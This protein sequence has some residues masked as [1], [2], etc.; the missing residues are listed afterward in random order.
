MSARILLR[1]ST[2]MCWI[3]CT[4]T[5]YYYT[6]SYVIELKQCNIQK[7][8]CFETFF[9][10]WCVFCNYRRGHKTVTESSHLSGFLLTDCSMKLSTQNCDND[11]C[12]WN[13][14]KA[15]VGSMGHLTTACYSGSH[16]YRQI[17][18]ITDKGEK[19][20]EKHFWMKTVT[21]KVRDKRLKRIDVYWTDN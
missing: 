11:W 13:N 5:K 18:K 21:K 12:H 6:D 20:T 17:Y 2:V 14:G 8:H 9:P 16:K 10:E 1:Q 15:L 7:C 4:A 3:C 19:I